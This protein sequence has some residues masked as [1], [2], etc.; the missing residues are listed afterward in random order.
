MRHDNPA[1]YTCPKSGNRGMHKWRR[2]AG[3]AVCLFCQMQ[4]TGD[5]AAEVFVGAETPIGKVRKA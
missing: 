4:L 3:G 1:C 2:N 5:H